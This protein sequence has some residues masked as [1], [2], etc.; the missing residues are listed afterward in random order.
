MPLL[1]LWDEEAMSSRDLEPT[2]QVEEPLSRIPAYA[3]TCVGGLGLTM[4]NCMCR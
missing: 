3:R 4:D 2:Q 1:G